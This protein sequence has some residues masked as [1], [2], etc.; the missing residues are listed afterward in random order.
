MSRSNRW[1]SR[2]TGL[3][4]W[5]DAR[6]RALDAGGWTGGI[7]GGTGANMAFWAL[8]ALGMGRC[9]FGTSSS[10]DAVMTDA[11]TPLMKKRAPAA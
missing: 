4:G 10:T 9:A 5:P 2:Q 1:R 3:A 8:M 6:P 7:F 11:A